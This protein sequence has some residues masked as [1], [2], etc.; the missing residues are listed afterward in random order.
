M[1]A[2]RA[3]RIPVTPI[4]VASIRR[5]P[6]TITMLAPPTPAAKPQDVRTLI[7]PAMTTMRA[8]QIHAPPHLA[9]ST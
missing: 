9:A 2:M 5:S 8:Q 4:W 3:Q 1:T 6:A 7:S